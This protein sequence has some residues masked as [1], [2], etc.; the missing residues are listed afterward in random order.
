MISGKMAAELERTTGRPVRLG[1]M[2]RLSVFWDRGFTIR[3]VP[4]AGVFEFPAEN[5]ALDRIAYVDVDTLR[6]LEWNGPGRCLSHAVTRQS[7]LD[8]L[9]GD[10]ADVFGSPGITEPSEAGIQLED[11]ERALAEP[12][13]GGELVPASAGSWNFILIRLKPG[14]ESGAIRAGL[15]RQL[16]AEGLKATVG[17]WREAG[18]SGASLAGSL[19]W[20]FNGALAL[21]VV[22]I[23]LI[24]ANSFVIW[25]TQRTA[26]IATMRAL[27]ASWGFVFS[28]LVVEAAILCAA[29]GGAGVAVGS[30]IVAWL[31]RRGV[32]TGNRILALVFGGATLRPVL[33]WPMVGACFLG[34]VTVGVLALL[35]PIRL[36]LR[37]HPARAMEGD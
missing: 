13:D 7:P 3:E 32:D 14:V 22:L 21:V 11:V 29:S 24:L 30:A 5:S 19:R 16:A 27:G 4:L 2:V 33:S 8:Y 35:L 1:D 20:A 17:D 28:L 31:S 12:R 23:A 10:L 18:G 36:A 15:E 9:T 6:T 26:E 25:I 34:S 37:M